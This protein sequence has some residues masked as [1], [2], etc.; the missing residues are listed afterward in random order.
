VEY[1]DG[2]SYIE[3]SFYLWDEGS[4]I[5]VIDVFDVFFNSVWEYFIEFFCVNV[6]KLNWCVD[7]F[8]VGSLYGL[9]LG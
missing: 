7:L 5:V 1:V 2:F 3:S 4:L 9:G 6:H 8:F